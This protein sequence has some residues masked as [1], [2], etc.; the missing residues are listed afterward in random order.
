MTLSTKAATAKDMRNAG[1]EMQHR[2]FATVAAIIKKLDEDGSMSLGDVQLVA[3][4]FA[5]E[6]AKTNPRFNR[7]R[8]MM[9]CGVRS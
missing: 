3:E 5:S 9:A 2:H 7:D 4:H 6:L 1:S 8:F